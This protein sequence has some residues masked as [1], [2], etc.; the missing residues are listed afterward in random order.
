MNAPMGCIEGLRSAYTP[1]RGTSPAPRRC[2][3]LRAGGASVSAPVHPFSIH[4]HIACIYLQILLKSNIFL[5]YYCSATFRPASPSTYITI[6]VHRRLGA[7][8]SSTQTT[9][10]RTVPLS[11]DLLWRVVFQHYERGKSPQEISD[12]LHISLRTVQRCLA[13]H[14]AT[15]DVAYHLATRCTTLH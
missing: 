2:S 4:W 7:L 1:F 3:A 5:S 13:R 11:E 6:T 12:N 10:P 14:R 8:S 9:M 15:G